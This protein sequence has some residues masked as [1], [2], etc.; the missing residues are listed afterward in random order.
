MSFA[1]V[2]LS[3]PDAA[4]VVSERSTMGN[5][6]PSA[7]FTPERAVSAE[8]FASAMGYAAYFWMPFVGSHAMVSV[9]AV[10]VT[11]AL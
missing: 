3:V 11:A 5:R 1:V 8:T 4:I 7:I 10:T 9:P 6:S 2:L